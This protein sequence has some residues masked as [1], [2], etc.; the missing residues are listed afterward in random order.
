MN[1][2][3]N[4]LFPVPVAQI[5]ERSPTEKELSFIKSSN[6]PKNFTTYSVLHCSIH[7]TSRFACDNAGCQ[8]QFLQTMNRKLIYVNIL[9]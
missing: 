7:D 6:K 1:V 2:N 3:M 8:H 5:E 4:G 9:N